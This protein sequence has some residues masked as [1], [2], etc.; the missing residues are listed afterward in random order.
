MPLSA[1]GESELPSR[2]ESAPTWRQCVVPAGIKTRI[3]SRSPGK[4]CI[5]GT[6]NDEPAV[7]PYF[8]S[9]PAF[10]QT[11]VLGISYNAEKIA[12]QTEFY[13]RQGGA[14]EH[15][16]AD[17]GCCGRTE[18]NM[19]V[20]SLI[21]SLSRCFG[22][23]HGNVQGA[24]AGAPPG[25][26]DN[27]IVGDGNRAAVAT[28][29]V[30]GQGQQLPAHGTA[31]ASNQPDGNTGRRKSGRGT[32]GL[33]L[34]GREWDALF[35]AT[36][37]EIQSG[38]GIR[39]GQRQQQGKGG[40]A[41]GCNNA[42]R[43]SAVELAEGVGRSSPRKN[44]P[45]S[46]NADGGASPSSAVATT[47]AAAAAK[48]MG[49]SKPS[50]TNKK[51]RA[52]DVEVGYA[53][54]LAKARRAANPAN[55]RSPTVKR[56]SPSDRKADIFRSRVYNDASSSAGGAHSSA[57]MGGSSRGNSF[58]SRFLSNHEGIAKSLCFANPIRDPVELAEEEAR[59]RNADT[60]GD[61]TLNTCEDTIT[62]TL[63]FDAKYSHVVEN[64]PPMPLFNQFKV[65]TE[66]GQ[67]DALSQI[68]ATQSHSS[69]NMIQLF[70]EHANTSQQEQQQQQQHHQS[71]GAFKP[72]PPAAAPDE[73]PQDPVKVMCSSS[74]ES[75]G[76]GNRAA[77]P[78]QRDS[79][80]QRRGRSK[81]SVT[82]RNSKSSKGSGKKSNGSS[83]AARSVASDRSR[84]SKNGSSRNSG[85]RSSGTTRRGSRP[86]VDPV[87]PA[88]P[89]QSR[90]TI[91][92]NIDTESPPGIKL[93][94]E[95]SRS[96]ST[97]NSL[98]PDGRQSGSNS[99]E[100]GGGRLGRGRVGSSDQQRASAQYTHEF[101]I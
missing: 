11:G 60:M 37:E 92:V 73:G 83:S 36:A 93:M 47:E 16:G 96:Q 64:R 87:E 76:S 58:A 44:G 42:R 74:D 4:R 86:R 28:A 71:R 17:A 65:D 68:V 55:H 29:V 51:N 15:S 69:L 6:G 48:N 52:P 7:F 13:R 72:L 8:G 82:S 75:S 84:G 22:N 77:D 97:N 70:Q 9:F 21:D 32:A 91:A 43:K 49:S 25:S 94:S 19:V 34:Q 62:S 20:K 40:N 38:A 30:R 78:N 1:L 56:K 41:S 88:T 3:T 27:S 85:S 53:E 31:M 89:P 59:L 80:R 61:N 95:S 67:E 2:N 24:C 23:A 39:K 35:D 33:E 26:A 66:P 90:T 101:A 81:A 54:V 99:N 10:D 63:Y 18:N 45:E 98:T 79:T 57:H 12:P 14:A 5:C 50:T 100:R 46:T